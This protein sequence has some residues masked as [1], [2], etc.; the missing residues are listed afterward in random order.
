[1]LP[2]PGARKQGGRALP[3]CLGRSQTPMRRHAS[4]RASNEEPKAHHSLMPPKERSNAAARWLLVLRTDVGCLARREHRRTQSLLRS[5]LPT[6]PRPMSDCASLGQAGGRHQPLPPRQA[7]HTQRTLLR[8]ASFA[9]MPAAG[10][11]ACWWR[12]EKKKEKQRRGATA[13]YKQVNKVVAI[14]PTTI[15]S[16][17]AIC[18]CKARRILPYWLPC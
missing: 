5:A 6:A 10:V 7:A 17:V 4:R 16:K 12:G 8:P 14:C 3:G 2:P 9:A 1:M 13:H 15:T 18:P 11:A